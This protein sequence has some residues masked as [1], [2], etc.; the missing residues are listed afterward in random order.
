MRTRKIVGGNLLSGLSSVNN[1]VR[2]SCKWMKT[3]D[4]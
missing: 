1:F 4:P 3:V 2:D